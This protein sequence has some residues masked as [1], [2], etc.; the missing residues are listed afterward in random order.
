[1]KHWP[2]N[3]SGRSEIYVQPFPGQRG[4]IQISA[5]GGSQ[6]PWRS[7][8][9]EFFYVDLDGNLMSVPMELGT[10]GRM[11][12]SAAIRFLSRSGSVRR[13]RQEQIK[14]DEDARYIKIR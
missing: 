6:V 2:I 8:G 4:D 5:N 14:R 3:K 12:A 9:K 7:N 13:S 10:D 11:A 1:V